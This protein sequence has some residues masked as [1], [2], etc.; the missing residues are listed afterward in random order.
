MNRPRET[1][2][3][4]RASCLLALF[5]L[6][7]VASTAFAHGPTVRLAYD[8]VTPEKVAIYAGQTIHFHNASRTART[9]TLRA[10]DG[11]FESP[12]LERGEGWH[13]QFDSPGTV[14]FV[15]VEYPRLG[16]TIV[17][18]EAE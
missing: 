5:V 4:C 9:F 18:A 17:I 16:G 3:G 14:V 13:H 15:V 8:R 11:S 1:G 6:T 7:T 2:I 10:E 12:P